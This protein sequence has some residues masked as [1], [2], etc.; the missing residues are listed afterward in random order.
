MSPQRVDTQNRSIGIIC[1]GYLRGIGLCISLLQ[2][3]KNLR[4]YCCRKTRN[5]LKLICFDGSYDSPWTCHNCFRRSKALV[6]SVVYNLY[7]SQWVDLTSLD[8]CCSLTNKKA[9]LPQRW[10][11][12][13]TCIWVPWKF[14]RDSEYAHGYFCQNF[15]GLLFRSIPRTCVQNLKFV[16][17]PIPEIIGGTQ[18]ALLSKTTSIR[19]YVTFRVG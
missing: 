1:T 15:N 17:L 8:N 19:S 10:P 6:C 5:D 12:D 3:M 11:R 14:S 9:E 4:F 18:K 16:A 13:A 2:K 7:R